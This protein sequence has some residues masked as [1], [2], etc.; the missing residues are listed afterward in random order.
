[1]IEKEIIEKEGTWG[2][3]RT[4]RSGAS[5]AEVE[6]DKRRVL[7]NLGEYLANQCADGLIRTVQLKIE[8][9][10]RGPQSR[11]D[12]FLAN[13]YYPDGMRLYSH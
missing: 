12:V 9:V 8:T 5:E 4:V 6:N 13:P 2:C 3:I 10:E 7:S 11:Y 1:M